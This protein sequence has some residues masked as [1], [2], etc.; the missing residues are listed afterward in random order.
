M[1]SR[2]ISSARKVSR[3]SELAKYVCFSPHPAIVSTTRSTSCR[4]EVSR[5]GT[6]ASRGS[7]LSG[8]RKY[9][10][11]TTL[12]AVCDHA[13]GTSTSFCSKTTRPSS[14]VITAVRRSHSTSDIGSTPGRVL[15]RSSAKPRV[16]VGLGAG[17]EWVCSVVLAIWFSKSFSKS[18]APPAIPASILPPCLMALF[19]HFFGASGDSQ[20]PAITQPVVSNT[21]QQY[22][23]I[24]VDKSSPKLRHHEKA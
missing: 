22:H 16:R 21:H 19:F 1:S 14:P 24:A 8:P 12:V 18:R 11:T 2:C 4:T 17:F 9:F 10:E 7:S 20:L 3:A 15:N 5:L 13:R 23:I 6:P